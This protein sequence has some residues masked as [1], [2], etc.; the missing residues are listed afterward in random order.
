MLNVV[1]SALR[2]GVIEL[3]GK[4]AVEAGIIRNVDGEVW[5]VMLHG[6]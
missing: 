4:P 1:A 2:T 3:V 6:V 5:N